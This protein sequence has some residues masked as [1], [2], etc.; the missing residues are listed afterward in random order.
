[1]CILTGTPPG[2]FDAGDLQITL[3][4]TW[5]QRNHISTLLW[6][7][8]LCPPPQFMKHNPPQCDGIWRQG[9]WEVIRFR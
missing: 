6:T 9:L 8:G 3:W 5:L 2:D 1:M 7:A 4:E